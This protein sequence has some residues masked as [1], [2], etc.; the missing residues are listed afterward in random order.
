MLYYC[1][2]ATL[3]RTTPLK[4]RAFQGKKGSGRRRRLARHRSQI[5]RVSE[6]LD[7]NILRP[8]RPGSLNVLAIIFSTYF[9][10]TANCVSLGKRNSGQRIYNNCAAR[11][12]GK[13][14]RII[15]VKTDTRCY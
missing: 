4:T 6:I 10:T 8:S 3:V 9:P 11:Y 15:V 14:K 1:C 2:A 13:Q 5:K 7:N 12:G